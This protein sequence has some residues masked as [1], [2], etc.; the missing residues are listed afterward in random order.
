MK[1][2]VRSVQPEHEHEF[3]AEPGLPEQL[4]AGER[5]LWQGQPQATL[6]AVTQAL[7]PYVVLLPFMRPS[8]TATKRD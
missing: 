3:E 2:V 7:V 5:V 6:Q 8:P 4:P 1:A